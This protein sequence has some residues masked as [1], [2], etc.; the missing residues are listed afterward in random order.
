V[1]ISP[2]VDTVPPSVNKYLLPHERQVITVKRHPVSIV[3]SAVSAV[4]GLFVAIAISPIV[5]GNDLL[6]LS[7][8]LLAGVLCVE[9][10]L[11][12][13]SWSAR[14]VVITSQRILF[15]SG[16]F[17]TRVRNVPL[18]TITNMTLRR[19]RGGRTFGYGTFI[20]DAAG[21]PGIVVDYLPYPE[22][23]Y[24][25]VNGLVFKDREELSD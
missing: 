14:W 17:G 8:W 9:F 25:E 18:E 5:Q 16:V 22:Q 3:P 13:I 2:S 7:I 6:E 10:V 23:L 21:R 12:C 24:L 11:A 4:G 15:V 19:P 20:F 1:R